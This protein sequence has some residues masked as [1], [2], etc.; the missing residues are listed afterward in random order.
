MS[1]KNEQYNR[2]KAYLG[3][4]HLDQRVQLSKIS[5]SEHVPFL[6]WII[7]AQ[8]ERCGENTVIHGLGK[9]VIYTGGVGENIP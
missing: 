1:T 5:N 9:K 7:S 4:T 8:R 3:L 6:E 2:P